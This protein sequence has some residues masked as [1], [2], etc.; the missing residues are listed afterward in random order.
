M[1][2]AGIAHHT[3]GGDMKI[4][5]LAIGVIAAIVVSGG[6]AAPAKADPVIAVIGDSSV[7]IQT[8]LFVPGKYECSKYPYTYQLGPDV[9]V[10]TIAILDA[11]GSNVDSDVLTT[12]GAGAGSFQVCSFSLEGK[13]SPFT[14]TLETSYTYDS[15]KADQAASSAPFSLTARGSGAVKCQKVSS[16]KKGAMKTFKAA[17]CPSGWR[18]V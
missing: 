11:Y 9:N 3:I 10:A 4:R 2:H 17:K 5:S 7:T 13:Q 8:P 15:G 1:R 12:A 16:P 18:K 14:L 6:I